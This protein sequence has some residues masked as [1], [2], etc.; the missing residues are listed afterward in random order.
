MTST[1]FR[2]YVRNANKGSYI[3]LLTVRF[4]KLDLKTMQLT[5]KVNVLFYT[6]FFKKLP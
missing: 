3:G 4:S 2:V 5:Q 1:Y 6:T